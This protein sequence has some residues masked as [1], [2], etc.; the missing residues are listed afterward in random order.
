MSTILLSIKPEY[1]S[2]IF[3]GTKKYEFRKHL[4]KKKVNKIIV[5]SSYPEQRII[6]E[7]EVI[8]ILSLKPT[9]LWEVTKNEA[10]I[11]RAKFRAYFKGCEKAYAYKLGKFKKYDTPKTLV[12]FGIKKPPQSFLYIEEK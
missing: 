1:S 10:G 2:R 11:S 12:E 9:P 3:E 4:A 8:D 7:V 6:G 5:Y